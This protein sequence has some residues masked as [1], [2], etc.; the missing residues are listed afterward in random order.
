M[1]SQIQEDFIYFPLFLYY[2]NQ[3][4]IDILN[5]K[6]SSLIKNL[7]KFNDNLISNF[8]AVNK[9]DLLE[10]EQV[11]ENAA[12]KYAKSVGAIFKL[13]SACTAAGV[14]ELFRAVGC[15]VLDP[16]FSEDDDAPKKQIAQQPLQQPKTNEKDS[17]KIKLDSQKPKEKEKKRGFC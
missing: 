5:N 3:N 17:G 9:S 8:I 11:N 10:K 16:N 4:I 7:T 2:Q 1:K 14:E 13:T 12:R 15:K 6:L